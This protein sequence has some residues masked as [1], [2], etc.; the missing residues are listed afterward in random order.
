M[1]V[2]TGPSRGRRRTVLGGGASSG[3]LNWCIVSAGRLGSPGYIRLFYLVLFELAGHGLKVASEQGVR[4]PVPAHCRSPRCPGGMPFGMRF[5]RQAG[6]LF[7][8]NLKEMSCPT[9]IFWK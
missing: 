4:E 6:V 7:G 8:V 3:F 1:A 9:G 5:S 2:P